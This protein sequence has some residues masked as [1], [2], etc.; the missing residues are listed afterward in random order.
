MKVC[1]FGG[2][3]N[4]VHNGHLIMAQAALEKFGLDRVVFIPCHLP[5]HKGSE[6]VVSSEDRLNMVRLAISG[7][8][9]FA[10]SDMEIKRGGRSYSIDT[11]KALRKKHGD[12]DLFF[13]IGA[14]MLKD[15]DSWVDAAELLKLCS[16]IVVERP[17]LGLAGIVK[18][19]RSRGRYFRRTVSEFPVG[20]SSTEIRK[21][22]KAGKTIRYLV[23]AAVEKYISRKGLYK[24]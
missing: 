18:G 4:P 5:P 19:L 13:L 7:N 15:F 21:R 16:F 3:F 8:S 9:K 10:V 14:D 22:V 17:G 12:G 24:K 23:P 20:I 6:E 2:T 1:I 11:V